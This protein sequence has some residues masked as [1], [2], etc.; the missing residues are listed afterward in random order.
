MLACHSVFMTLVLLTY[1]TRA[2]KQSLIRENNT[3]TRSLASNF[4]YCR[5]F[6]NNIKIMKLCYFTVVLLVFAPFVVAAF[7]QS[8]A[9]S[10][11][12]K[13]TNPNKVPPETLLSVSHYLKT[14]PEAEAIIR[15]R[16]TAWINKDPSLAPSI[17]RLH[18]HDCAVRVST[19]IATFNHMN[20]LQSRFC[21][22]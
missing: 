22:R 6:E 14:C 11:P 3:Q 21:I 5:S 2:I 16:M 4:P 18:F 17:I 15:R 9:I 1:S 13:S 8:P 20:F 7:N 19:Y 12:I 10:R